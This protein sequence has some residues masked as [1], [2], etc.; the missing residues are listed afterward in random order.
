MFLLDVNILIAVA[1]ADHIH[2]QRAQEFFQANH[3]AGWATCPLTENAF[4]RIL[5]HHAYPKGPGSSHLARCLLDML[6]GRPGH[7]FWPDGISLRTLG[8][9]PVSKHLTDHYLLGLAIHHN[10]KLATMDQRI[11]ATA[12]AGGQNA[13]VVI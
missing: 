11:D 2:H 3:A 4:V 12:L 7:A 5:G 9:L 10:A 6:C 1:D 13:Y 8:T